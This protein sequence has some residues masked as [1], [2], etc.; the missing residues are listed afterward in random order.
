MSRPVDDSPSSQS[1]ICCQYRDLFSLLLLITA[2]TLHVLRYY[3]GG[4][5]AQLLLLS[6]SLWFTSARVTDKAGTSRSGISWPL[7]SGPGRFDPAES[8]NRGGNLSRLDDRR[9]I[10]AKFSFINHLDGNFDLTITSKASGNGV[11]YVTV[12]EAHE[13]Q[14][15]DNYLGRHLKGVPKSRL[16]NILRR[17]EVRVNKGRVKP[18]Y[19]VRCGDEIRIPPVRTAEKSYPGQL[20]PSLEQRLG[21][22]VL[23]END[24]LMVVNKPS[25]LAVHG[26]SGISLGLIEAL[27]LLRPELHYLELVHRL[28]RDTSGCVML[29]KKRSML[30]FLHEQLRSGG[31]D[32]RYWALVSGR[33]SK[34]KTAV[35]APLQKNVLQ[36]GERMVRV[37]GEGKPSLTEFSI[38]ENF[39][40][41]TLVEARPVTG[42]THQI[43][44]HAQVAGHPLLG[45]EK[46][47]DVQANR[48]FKS[49]GLKRLF[50]HAIELHVPSPEG[51]GIQVRAP[52]DEDLDEL[53]KRLREA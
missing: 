28:D 19:R 8:F 39:A 15:I 35:S 11:Q 23:Y 25:G 20:A 48:I 24:Q 26:G 41:A 51:D 7:G 40:G 16:Y 42:R 36:S 46:Y 52:L 31:V 1:L 13:G 10:A 5:R 38:V 37:E 14:R 21:Q 18:D 17:G 30:R 34:R 49:L 9:T 45:D 2:T 12:A 22:A 29:A 3:C 4:D 47:G 50:L 53:L 43:R 27:R 6:D 33:W 32:K 44:V